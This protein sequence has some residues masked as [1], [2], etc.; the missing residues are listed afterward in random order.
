MTTATARRIYQDLGPA[1]GEQA[2]MPERV[3]EGQY[4]G[5]WG[6]YSARFE[7]GTEKYMLHLDRGIEPPV[8]DCTVTVAGGKVQVATLQ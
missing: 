1:T 3:P 2:V 6:G 7:I 5:R 4:P 8:Q